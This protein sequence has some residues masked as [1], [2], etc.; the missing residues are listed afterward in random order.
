MSFDIWFDKNLQEG[1]KITLKWGIGIDLFL[2]L[3]ILHI[4]INKKWI[5]ESQLS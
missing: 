5:S 2:H 3:R 1:N 4:W